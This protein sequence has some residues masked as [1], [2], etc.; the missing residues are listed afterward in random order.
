[1]Y[2]TMWGVTDFNGYGTL[3]DYDITDKLKNISVPSLVIC[4]EFDEA[5]PRTCHRYAT[6]IE[7]ATTVIV[8]DA[9]HAT[10]SANE[11]MYIKAV[12]DFLDKALR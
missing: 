11:S 3:K 12:R 2:V 7:N 1:M 8:P 6:M 5:R 10:M 4:G 9:G